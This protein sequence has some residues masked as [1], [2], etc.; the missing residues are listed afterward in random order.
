MYQLLGTV[1][2]H[3]PRRQDKTFCIFPCQ[4]SEQQVYEAL[5]ASSNILPYSCQ[6][7][8]SLARDWEII[9]ADYF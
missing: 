3:E 6:R 1:A 7:W 4:A 2:N 5:R 9:E 8:R